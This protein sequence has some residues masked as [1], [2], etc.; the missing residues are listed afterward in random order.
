MTTIWDWY[1]TNVALIIL[2]LCVVLLAVR[3]RHLHR[4]FWL[5]IDL[6]TAETIRQQAHADAFKKLTDVDSIMD[7]MERGADVMEARNANRL[8]KPREDAGPPARVYRPA[9]RSKLPNPWTPKP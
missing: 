1:T 8:T 5:S 2:A 4:D 3:V 7:D 9:M 6:I